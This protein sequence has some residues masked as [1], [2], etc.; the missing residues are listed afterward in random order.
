MV[1][2]GT[3]PPFPAVNGEG[4][5][6]ADRGRRG[7][8]REG[9]D[10]GATLSGCGEGEFRGGACA[11]AA[12]AHAAH[13]IAEVRGYDRGEFATVFTGVRAE[14]N[15]SSR[16][17]GSWFWGRSGWLGQFASVFYDKRRERERGKK[18]V[19]K[20]HV[21]ER[22]EKEKRMAGGESNRYGKEWERAVVLRFVSES[23][24]RL[25]SGADGSDSLPQTLVV[26]KPTRLVRTHPSGVP[27]TLLLNV[28]DRLGL[29]KFNNRCGSIRPLGTYVGQFHP[30]NNTDLRT[31]H[32]T[33][34]SI[35]YHKNLLHSLL[36]QAKPPTSNKHHHFY[37][38]CT[39]SDPPQQS[40]PTIS[41]IVFQNL[42]HL[43][44]NSFSTPNA[45]GSQRRSSFRIRYQDAHVAGRG[46]GKSTPA[47]YVPRYRPAIS[48]ANV[49]TITVKHARAY[50]VRATVN[51]ANARAEPQPRDSTGEE[52]GGGRG[53]LLAAA[54]PPGTCRVSPA[55][56]WGLL[57]SQGSTPLVFMLTASLY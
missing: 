5:S 41:T 9:Q 48:S 18:A 28:E 34:T 49:F 10:N 46:P 36:F 55:R 33:S 22:G 4:P 12:A 29:D 20:E 8:T 1:G 45:T 27:H 24:P 31:V 51:L 26:T 37:R 23:L 42:L 43:P 16:I 35:R 21:V 17:R 15:E 56:E 14:L 2:R 32:L 44:S 6:R 11:N 53:W 30:S 13:W 25:I 38:R 40:H 52:G 50:D 3:G 57:A 47:V 7:H 39:L 19:G 54:L